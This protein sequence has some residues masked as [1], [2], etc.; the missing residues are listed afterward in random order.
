MVPNTLQLNKP[1]R[2]KVSQSGKPHL[3]VYMVS[4][5]IRYCTVPNT[6]KLMIPYRSYYIKLPNTESL[7]I[8]LNCI[9]IRKTPS[10]GLFGKFRHIILYGS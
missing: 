8:H 10:G 9:L 1:G 4:L 7:L 5:S 6:I 3:E 2:M